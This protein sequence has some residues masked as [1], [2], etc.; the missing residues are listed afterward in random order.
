MRK[1]NHRNNCTD[2]RICKMIQY[3]ERCPLCYTASQILLGIFNARA[4]GGEGV[5]LLR[6]GCYVLWLSV[7]HRGDKV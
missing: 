6:R 1:P 4:G 5:V 3:R 2:T 7:Y